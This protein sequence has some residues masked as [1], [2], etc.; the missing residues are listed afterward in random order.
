MIDEKKKKNQ[1]E[2]RLRCKNFS[3][4]DPKK[5]IVNVEESGENLLTVENPSNLK[6]DFKEENM[7]LK[8]QLMESYEKAQTIIEENHKEIL[9]IKETHEKYEQQKDEEVVQLKDQLRRET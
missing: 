7:K 3:F 8:Q 9:K 2:K 4:A 5:C 6:Y 1:L